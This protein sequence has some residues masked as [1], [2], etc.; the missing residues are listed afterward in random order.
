M[1]AGAGVRR[2]REAAQARIRELCPP[3]VDVFPFELYDSADLDR[4][5]V[6]RCRRCYRPVATGT[7]AELR[8]DP[9]AYAA[10]VRGRA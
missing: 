3:H 10:A 8:A 5:P 4:R 1:P 9:D 6:V 7:L 2:E